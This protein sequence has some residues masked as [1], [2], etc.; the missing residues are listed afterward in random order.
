MSS[1]VPRA[2]H[3]VVLAG[4][5]ALPEEML[6]AAAA[7]LDRAEL[8]VAADG[9][10]THALRLGRQV[11]V[12]VGD[13]DSVGPGVA[14]RAAA[15]GTEI[16]RHPIDKDATDLALALDLVLART[17]RD[18]STGRGTTAPVEVTVIGGHGGRSDHLLGNALL[19]GAD[20]YADLRIRALWGAA[21]LTVVR[22]DATLTGRPGALVSLLALHGPAQGVRTTGLRH[23]LDG[24]TL[25]P[26][27]S[28]GVSNRFEATAA[29]VTLTGGV[30]LAV[31]PERDRA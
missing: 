11:D 16:Q 6:D 10:I 5:D 23:P 14:E 19:L 9:G 3:V 24:A 2:H 25:L 30:I 27:S 29:G 1:P 8:V 21:V 22:D 20:R 4:G 17:P 26:G 7:A 18:H 12:L 28:L 31:Q 13:L 15:D